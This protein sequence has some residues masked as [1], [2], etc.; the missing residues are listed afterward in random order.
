MQSLKE[1]TESFDYANDEIISTYKDIDPKHPLIQLFVEAAKYPDVPLINQTEL[2]SI[3][4]AHSIEFNS[5][6]FPSD[7]NHCTWNNL[8]REVHKYCSRA[9]W[10]VVQDYL[11]VS[12]AVWLAYQEYLDQND[13][14]I[15]AEVELAKEEQN[16]EETL[17]ESLWT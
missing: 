8:M 5:D 6:K 12:L 7:T 3:L 13:P 14:A 10:R 11:Y 2:E 1:F 17:R 15:Q 9:T 16:K 4:T